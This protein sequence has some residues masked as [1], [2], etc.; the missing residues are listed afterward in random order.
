MRST[1]DAYSATDVCSGR[2]SF[3]SIHIA[4]GSAALMSS[5]VKRVVIADTATATGYMNPRVTPAVR[6]TPAMMNENSPICARLI[7][8]CMEC[9]RPAPVM[10]APAETAIVL[11][12]MTS[13]LSAIT[14]TQFSR[15]SRGSIR[16][17]TETKK[18]ATNM[19][20]TG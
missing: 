19:S 3:R 4:A 9:L 1:H 5:G 12:A 11:P 2:G 17:P 15:T 14:A 16:D 10:N 7:P 18:I 6:P 13:A 20:R 8:V